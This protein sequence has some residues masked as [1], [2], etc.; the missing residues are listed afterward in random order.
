MATVRELADGEYWMEFDFGEDRHTRRV[1]VSHDDAGIQRVRWADEAWQP[2]PALT[3]ADLGLR[4]DQLPASTLFAPREPELQLAA[5]E[6]SQVTTDE[7]VDT[8]GRPLR[9]GQYDLHQRNVL[10][11]T[12]VTV[13]E[14]DVTG[15]L[16]AVFANRGGQD[17]L[18]VD[19]LLK[20]PDF[21]WERRSR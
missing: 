7:V 1:V 10:T 16:V 14:D 21:R 8:A 4:V 20:N 13:E 6:C 18:L 15:Q 19:S 5:D 12:R 17:R 9:A 11:P 2:Q 3:A